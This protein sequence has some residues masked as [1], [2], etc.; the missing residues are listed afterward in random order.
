MNWY[1]TSQQTYKTYFVCSDCRKWGFSP[2]NNSENAIWKS[3]EEMTPEERATVEQVEIIAPRGSSPD[4]S[5]FV[6]HTFCD[7][8]YS[9]REKEVDG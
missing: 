4:G 5:I 6:S 1:K 3:K 7:D 9:I 2:D 8:C